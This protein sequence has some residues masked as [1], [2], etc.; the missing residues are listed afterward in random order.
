M[1]ADVSYRAKIGD[2]LQMPFANMD[3]AITRLIQHKYKF[4]TANYTDVGAKVR[5]DYAWKQSRYGLFA[6]LGGG[7][8][9]CSASEHQAV[10]HSSIGITF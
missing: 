6:E 10:L 4:A 8:T 9:L 3:A 7:M 2:K 1:N 5:A